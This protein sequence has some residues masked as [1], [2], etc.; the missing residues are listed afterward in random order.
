MYDNSFASSGVSCDTFSGVLSCAAFRECFSETSVGAC[1]D[2]GCFRGLVLGLLGG[3]TALLS[4]SGST[5]P[6]L[7]TVKGGSFVCG[8]LGT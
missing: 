6:E 8:G 1:G 7:I 5:S 2:E 4:G 3:D